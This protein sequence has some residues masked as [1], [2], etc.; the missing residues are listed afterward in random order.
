[1]KRT[2]VPLLT[3]SATLVLGARCLAMAPVATA[4]IPALATTAQSTQAP[5]ADTSGAVDTATLHKYL[6]AS[7]KIADV[8]AHYLPR[9]LAASS[10]TVK[11][12]LRRKEATEIRATVSRIM[13]YPQYLA[14]NKEINRELKTNP[15]FRHRLDTARGNYVM[16][17]AA[18]EEA[19]RPA[20][21]APPHPGWPPLTG[22]AHWDLQVHEVKKEPPDCVKWPDGGSFPNPPPF[23]VVRNLQGYLTAVSFYGPPWTVV[24]GK[25]SGTL[26]VTLFLKLSRPLTVCHERVAHYAPQESPQSLTLSLLSVPKIDHYTYE[27]FSGI[28]GIQIGQWIGLSDYHWSDGHIEVTGSPTI[29]REYF[30]RYLHREV[31]VWGRLHDLDGSPGPLTPFMLDVT[32]VCIVEGGKEIASSCIGSKQ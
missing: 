2:I 19:M 14:L 17:M 30:A 8:N 23:A 6:V 4:R 25:D 22:Q 7:Y 9:I 1:M 32:G 11:A 18:K 12:A 10:A 27:N 16:E 5:A 3:V 20:F 28:T 21:Y 29:T 24:N 13:P 31:A 15:A 26:A